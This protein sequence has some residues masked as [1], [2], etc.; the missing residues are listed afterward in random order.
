MIFQINQSCEHSKF[1][2]IEKKNFVVI[3]YNFGLRY[4]MD[5]IRKRKKK[6]YF[7]FP[8]C[9]STRNTSFIFNEY[10]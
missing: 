10:S 9:N 4:M 8:A 6:E 1:M 3:I 2:S 5:V 7:F